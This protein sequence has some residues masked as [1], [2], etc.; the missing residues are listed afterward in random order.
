MRERE[1]HVVAAEQDMVADRHPD[2][3]EGAV[4]LH[5]GDRREVSRS[6]ADVDDQHHVAGLQLRAPRVAH[7]ERPCVE[8]GLRLL[9]QRQVL[10]PGGE[11]GLDGELARGRIEGGGHGDH[12]VL[13]HEGRVASAEALVEGLREVLEVA[14][15]RLDGRDLLDV[16]GRSERENARAAIHGGM[17]EPALGARDD[18]RRRVDPARAR[19]LADGER[20]LRVPWKALRTVGRVREVE[21]RGQER[22]RLDLPSRDELRDREDLRP[23]RVA[24]ERRDRERGVGRAEIDAHGEA[25]HGSSTSAGAR[26]CASWP[27]TICGSSRRVARQPRCRSTPL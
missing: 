26:T 13:L 12:D 16:F 21:E 17:R 6:P 22:G 3:V 5:G 7:P 25:R 4:L 14:P 27:P 8:G 20:A 23:C 1:V 19:I 11:R 2:Q 18:A 15:R 10:D 24:V 9:E